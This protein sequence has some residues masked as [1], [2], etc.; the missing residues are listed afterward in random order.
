M[1]NNP[2]V[3]TQLVVRKKSRTFAAAFVNG[4][5]NVDFKIEKI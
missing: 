5:D 2:F 3:G 1:K 4:S